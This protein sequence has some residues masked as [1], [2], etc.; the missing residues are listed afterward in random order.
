MTVMDK[1]EGWNEEEWVGS[2]LAASM[3]INTKAVLF[4]G[5]KSD[6]TLD[7]QPI[8]AIIVESVS[9]VPEDSLWD[10]EWITETK[11]TMKENLILE[12][13]HCFSTYCAHFNG[14]CY[15]FQHRQTSTAS[16]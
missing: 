9:W 6:P 12:A 1:V 14:P 15:G 7:L 2:Y 5:R 11:V 8:L 3:W 10:H 4:Y 13:P 16:S